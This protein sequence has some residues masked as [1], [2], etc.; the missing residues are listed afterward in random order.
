[1][2]FGIDGIVSGLDTT[3]IIDALV[4]VY[5]APQYQLEDKVETQEDYKSHL[6]EF[7]GLIGD[8]QDALEAM[9]TE[10]EF[11]SYTATS[12]SSDIT[13]S[14]SA[15]AISGT[16]SLSVT[17]L[18]TSAIHT[19]QGYASRDDL[20]AV[21][22]GTYTVTYGLDSEGDPV[23]FTFE[24]D[25]TNNSLDEFVA[26]FNLAVDGASAYVVD[27]GIAGAERYRMVFAGSD[28]GADNA[29]D[30]T[31]SAPVGDEIVLTERQAAADAIFVLDGITMHSASNTVEDALPGVT[32][33][34]LD[35]TTSAARISIQPDTTAIQ[36]KISS[37]V[38]AFNA[39]LEYVDTQT[40]FDSEE[41]IRGAFVGDSTVRSVSQGLS[42]AVAS[43]YGSDTFRSLAEIGIT[44]DW[45]TGYLEFD[46]STFNDAVDA[47]AE[48][49]S[50]LFTSASGAGAAILEKIDLYIDPL[51]GTLTE[52]AESID[53]IIEDYNERIDE[54]ED[55]ATRYEDRLWESFTNMEVILGEL[56]NTQNTL[57]ALLDW[58][59]SSDDE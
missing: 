28:T 57:T 59:T 15:G 18:A 45:E 23:E 12:T 52:R 17:D 35:E 10:D 9:D 6:T 39:V 27:T 38:S 37:F 33:T 55:R 11:W 19:S 20:G 43:A 1:M 2:G 50:A 3:S 16:H 24:I 25:G 22:T 32:F 53:E 13:V 42:M 4:E 8:L 51:D 31:V 58:N 30:M 5:K 46:A 48:A 47:D 44:T 41:D 56:E 7:M 40:A 26:A 54:W 21:A 36:T 49:V 29:L 34:L 14:A